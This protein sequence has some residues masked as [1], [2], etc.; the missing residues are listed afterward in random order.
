MDTHAAFDA[1]L[2]PLCPED[3]LHRRLAA[4]NRQR[5][6]PAFPDEDWQ[7]QTGA[8]LT[9]LQEEHDWLETLRAEIQAEAAAAPTTPQAFR[10][11][12]EALKENGPG[13]KDPLFPWLA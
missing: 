4:L 3:R 8:R 11:W 10:A 5:F 6:M 2:L 12:F 9:L 7:Q 1:A 13:Q